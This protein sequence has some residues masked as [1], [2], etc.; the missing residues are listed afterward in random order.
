MDLPLFQFLMMENLMMNHKFHDQNHQINMNKYLFQFLEVIH[1][2][3]IQSDFM[4]IDPIWIHQNHQN[5]LKRTCYNHL[6]NHCL[7]LNLLLN[8]VFLLPNLVSKDRNLIQ[9]KRLQLRTFI[10]RRDFKSL[11]LHQLHQLLRE[12]EYGTFLKEYWQTG[13]LLDNLENV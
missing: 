4:V 6:L 2:N 7:L 12:K 5:P 13:C 1:L 11:I 10:R 9:A 3:L 8:N